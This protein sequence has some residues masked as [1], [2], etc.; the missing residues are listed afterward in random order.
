M[1]NAPP[2]LEIFS[3]VP[4]RP[5]G[6]R[7]VMVNV[8]ESR[9]SVFSDLH[10]QRRLQTKTLLTELFFKLYLIIKNVNKIFFTKYFVFLP[11]KIGH[12]WRKSVALKSVN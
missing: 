3:I 12:F 10:S 1:E 5:G 2:G 11:K 4:S 7:V 6:S 8:S 9:V